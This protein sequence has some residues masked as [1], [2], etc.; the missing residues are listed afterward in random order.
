MGTYFC[1]NVDIKTSLSSF[2]H[3]FFSSFTHFITFYIHI[4]FIFLS[5]FFYTSSSSTFFSLSFSLFFSNFIYLWTTSEFIAYKNRG[6]PFTFT[7]A[8]FILKIFSC[9]FIIPYFVMNYSIIK[10][11]CTFHEVYALFTNSLHSN[12]WNIKCWKQHSTIVN[13]QT[14]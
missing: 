12:T 9:H 8:L 14:I 1:N 5:L 7:H 4:F 3:M 13:T 10:S 2:F 6:H 11:R